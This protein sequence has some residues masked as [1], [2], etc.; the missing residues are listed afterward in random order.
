MTDPAMRQ[1]AEDLGPGGRRDLL[2][3][4]TSPEN[5]RADVIRQFHERGQ[6]DMVDLLVLLEEQ[7]WNRQAMIEELRQVDSST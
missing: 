6:E 3:V 1:L 4:L 2:R 5:V 7:E